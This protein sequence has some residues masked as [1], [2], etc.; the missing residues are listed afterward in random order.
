MRDLREIE[1]VL[2]DV[3]LDAEFA[4]AVRGLD[5]QLLLEFGGTK[6]R[7]RLCDTS[8]PANR[9]SDDIVISAPSSVWERITASVPPP[10][11]QSFTAVQRLVA[12]FKVAGDGIVVARAL[13]AIERLFELMR[14]DIA[15]APDTSSEMNPAAVCGRYRDLAASGRR[16]RLYY[17]TAGSGIPIV[18]LHTAGADSRQFHHLLCDV[19]IGREWAMHAFD[20]PMHGRSFPPEDWEAGAYTLT[21]SE[22]ADWCVAFIEGVVGKPA[23]VIGCSMGAAIA[24]TLAATHSG[25]LL[26]VVALEAPDKS[27]GRRNPLLCHPEVN[28]PSYAPSYV[29]GLMSPAS[30][31]RHRRLACWY[32]NQGGSESIRGIS[33]FT[34]K[35]TMVSSSRKRSTRH[36]YPC[37]S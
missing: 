34:A 14:Q 24:M 8:P 7:L 11:Y 23:V 1:Q 35:N 32:Y 15:T 5:L 2:A 13:H 33:P 22:Y 6:L 36:A 16:C 29:R 12:D 9:E 27:P 18:F 26:G 21:E 3:R 19:D 20:M 17:E 4:A 28:Q 25:S 31:L 10:G 37:S 30:P